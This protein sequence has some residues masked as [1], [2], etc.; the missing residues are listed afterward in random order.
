MHYQDCVLRAQPQDGRRVGAAKTVQM[1]ADANINP[2]TGLATDYLN[3]FNEAI[4]LLEMLSSFPDCRD[5]I[6]AWRP[7]SYCEHFAASRLSTRDLAI[8]V[9]EAVDAP[10]RAELEALVDDMHAVMA[11]TCAILAAGVD[12]GVAAA[13]GSRAALRLRPLAAAAAATING[14]N[15]ATQAIVDD[16]LKS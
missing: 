3:H 14:G 1:L 10:L 5:D 4:M 8:A 15:D 16:L 2:T 6:L 7:L 13:I 12:P 11:E 9:Y